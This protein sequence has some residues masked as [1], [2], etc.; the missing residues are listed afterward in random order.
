[1]TPAPSHFRATTPG[2]AATD[3]AGAP[4]PSVGPCGRTSTSARSCFARTSTAEEL[5]SGIELLG[6]SFVDSMNPDH[7]QDVDNDGLLEP[8][9]HDLLPND[10]PPIGSGWGGYVIWLRNTTDGGK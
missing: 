5:P 6:F 1:M 9:G 10:S 7:W 8:A 3:Q 2:S 4:T